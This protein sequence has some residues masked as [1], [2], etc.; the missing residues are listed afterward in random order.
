[1]DEDSLMEVPADPGQREV[2]LLA[3]IVA[4]CDLEGIHLMPEVPPKVVANAVSRYLHLRPDELLL[5]IV[6][7]SGGRPGRLGFAFTTRRFCYAVLRGQAL[8][9]DDETE[10]GPPIPKGCR[11]VAFE[12]LPE[13]IGVSGGL[14]PA[15]D[16]GEARPPT[17][18]G[19]GRADLHRLAALLRDLGRIARGEPT[20]AVVPDAEAAARA[21]CPS[22]PRSPSRPAPSRPASGRMPPSC[23]RRPRASSPRPCSPGSASSSTSPWSSRASARSRRR[24]RTSTPGV[25]TSARR[26]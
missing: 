20:S 25:P 26:W 11:S 24:L 8:G 2:D 9:T 19:L 17:P 21:C 7:R 10:P 3:R 23:G 13:S 18:P 5:A 14:V 1:M 15:L 22:W 12:D 6:D 16:L 4:D